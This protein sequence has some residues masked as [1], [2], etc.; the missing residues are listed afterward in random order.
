[1]TIDLLYE[2]GANGPFK[3]TVRNVQMDRITATAAPRVLYVVAF[4]GATTGIVRAGVVQRHVGV[5]HALAVATRMLDNVLDATVWPLPAQQ[6][7]AANKRRV[8]LGFTG[9]GDTLI[10]MGLRYKL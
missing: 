9:L 6:Q 4:D 5:R 2:E 3:P 10:M 7:E 8:G 1:M